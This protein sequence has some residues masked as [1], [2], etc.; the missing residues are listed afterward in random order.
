MPTF[1]DLDA[2]TAVAVVV[3]VTRVFAP[4]EHIAPSLVQRMLGK[5]MRCDGGTLSVPA[6]SRLSHVGLLS[7]IGH[8]PGVL[9]APA[10]VPL[11][12][13]S[14]S[15]MGLYGPVPPVA[16][17]SI[18]PKDVFVPPGQITCNADPNDPWN[19]LIATCAP[20][21]TGTPFDVVA[22]AVPAATHAVTDPPLEMMSWHGPGGTVTSATEFVPAVTCR[23]LSDIAVTA[24][25]GTT[26]GTRGSA[27]T[28]SSRTH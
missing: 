7:Q 24:T 12:P 3:P 26:P 2:A 17:E 16:V 20:A 25:P 9:P 13:N 15:E 10:G 11:I 4:P 18:Y 27:S 8:A 22:A 23:V 6:R 14:I 19:A 28:S 5:A 1:T 21:A